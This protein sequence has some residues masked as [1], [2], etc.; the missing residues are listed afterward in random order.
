MG[1]VRD[2]THTVAPPGNCPARLGPVRLPR[3]PHGAGH[4]SIRE[5]CLRER[6]GACAGGFKLFREQSALPMGERAQ[7]LGLADVVS[8]KELPA[9]RGAPTTLAHQQLPN[10]PRE[11]LVG[12]VQDDCRGGSFSLSDP[13]LQLRT[14]QPDHVR[15]FQRSQSLRRRAHCGG[16][17][18]LVLRLLPFLRLGG[19]RFLRTGR[20][21]LGPPPVGPVLRTA[22]PHAEALGFCSPPFP[23]FPTLPATCPAR[24]SR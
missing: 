3:Q 4:V 7:H 22:F 18:H 23:A 5:L 2:D 9:P 11:R 6:E 8:R 12:R 15:S 19:S 1:T 24:P 14:G 20:G 21:Q 13:S 17:R 10:R 16:L